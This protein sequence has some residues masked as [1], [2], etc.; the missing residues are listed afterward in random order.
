MASQLLYYTLRKIYEPVSPQKNRF[1]KV[2]QVAKERKSMLLK[3]FVQHFCVRNLLYTVLQSKFLYNFIL[4]VSY[5]MESW[6]WEHNHVHFRLRAITLPLQY[7]SVN[8]TPHAQL[9]MLTNIP[10]KFHDP[11]SDLIYFWNYE[12]NNIWVLNQGQ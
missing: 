4:E 12:I 11:N 1:S 9:H 2:L 6:K 7:E 10:V 8:E 5:F 3:N